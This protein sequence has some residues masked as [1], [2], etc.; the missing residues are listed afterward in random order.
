MY[1]VG[2]ILDTIHP[3]DNNNMSHAHQERRYAGE[4]GVDT[5]TMIKNNNN[6]KT[7]KK[8]RT[9]NN[10]KTDRKT[11]IILYRKRIIIK[12]K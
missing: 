12:K 10:N 7:K 3:F 1:F 2:E 6:N 9:N 5:R 4:C 8:N 11:I